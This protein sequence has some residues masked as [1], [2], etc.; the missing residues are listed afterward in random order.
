[1]SLAA[2]SAW[3]AALPFEPSRDNS[4]VVGKPEVMA[5]IGSAGITSGLPVMGNL[6]QAISSPVGSHAEAPR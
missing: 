5:R 2:G 1:M 6:S 4:R 3:N